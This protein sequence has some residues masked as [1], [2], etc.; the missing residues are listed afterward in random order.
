MVSVL[1]SAWVQELLLGYPLPTPNKLTRVK[2]VYMHDQ[3]QDS[4]ERQRPAADCHGVRTHT[5]CRMPP[6][7]VYSVAHG[8]AP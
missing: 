8:G 7:A 3:K 1:Q 5:L 6:A 2:R 4:Q